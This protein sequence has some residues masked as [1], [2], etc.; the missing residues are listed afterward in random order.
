SPGQEKGAPGG[1]PKKGKGGGGGGGTGKGG[2]GGGMRP[3]AKTQLTVLVNKLDILVTKPLSVELTPEQKKKVLD[4][5]K[6]LGEKEELSEEE[7]QKHLD[8]LLA[9]LESK[10]DTLEAAGFRWPGAAANPLPQPPPNPFKDGNNEK[11][12]KSLN[13]QLRKSAGN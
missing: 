8:A 13:A 9:L 1:M 5:I 10:K 7:A 12:L 2:G 3:T 6:E 4:E 11:H